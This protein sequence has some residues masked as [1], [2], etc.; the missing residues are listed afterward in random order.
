M[1]TLQFSCCRDNIHSDERSMC[2]EKTDLLRPCVCSMMN[3]CKFMPFQTCFFR[4]CCSGAVNPIQNQPYRSLS[5][6]ELERSTVLQRVQRIFLFLKGSS[7]DH[8][9]A[10]P[11]VKPLGGLLGGLLK[12][13][14]PRAPHLTH[15]GSP[16]VRANG[17]APSCFHLA[18]WWMSMSRACQMNSALSALSAVG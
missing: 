10:T 12:V 7:S 14:L 15:G 1:V 6:L 3:L 4:F 13:Q 16:A 2:M 17:H 8:N 18:P 9:S 11:M 5:T